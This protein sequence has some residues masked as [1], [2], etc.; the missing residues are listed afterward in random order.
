MAISRYRPDKPKY[1]SDYYCLREADADA[2]ATV[3]V[4]RRSE[5]R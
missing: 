5:R 3:T 4:R 1:R 2:D